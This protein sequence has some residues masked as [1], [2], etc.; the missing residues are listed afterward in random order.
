MKKKNNTLPVPSESLTKSNTNTATK[1]LTDAM[2][3]T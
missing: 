3:A 2:I 1:H